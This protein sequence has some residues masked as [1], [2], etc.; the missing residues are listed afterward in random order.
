MIANTKT[1][2]LVLVFLVGDQAIID[3]SMEIDARFA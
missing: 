2:Q 3:S 1:S